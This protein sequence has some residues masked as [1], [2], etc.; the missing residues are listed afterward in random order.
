MGDDG[1]ACGGAASANA[2][3]GSVSAGGRRLGRDFLFLKTWVK[4]FRG[5]LIATY[6]VRT[7]FFSSRDFYS[8]LVDG[9][10]PAVA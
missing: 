8:T 10:S 3:W 6:S 4:F 2:G 1:R 9:R 5:R 7:S